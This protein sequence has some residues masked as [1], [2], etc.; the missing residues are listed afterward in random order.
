MLFWIL[1]ALLTLGAC[2]AVLL[3]AMRGGGRTTADTDFDLTV[4]Q[5]QLAELERDMARGVI[6][7]TEAQQARAEIGRRILKLAGDKQAAG[8]V[9][10]GRAGRVLATLAI[11]ALPVTSWGIYTTTGS[12]HL[13][14]QPLQ[15][16]LDAN[17][18]Q[19]PIGML[20]ARA[21]SHLTANPEDGRGWDVLAPIYYRMGRYADASVAYRNAIRLLGASDVR[22]AGLGEALAA[23]AG[24]MITDEAQAALER[25]IAIEPSNPKARF[26]LVTAMAQEGRDDDARSAWLSMRDDLPEDSPWRGAV[27]QALAE[28]DRQAAGAGPSS[29]EIEAAG[30]M[31]D[32]DRTQMI[33]DMVAGLDQRLRTNPQDA[34][35]W[36]R[37]VHSYAVMGRDDAAGDALSR[38]LEALGQD[39]EAGRALVAFAAERGV[40]A[41]N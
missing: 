31:S 19:D 36:Q 12:P 27:A 28:L 11:L 1:A 7:S 40:R 32:N 39:S 34:E 38:G 16:R 21:E 24:G 13:H 23:A 4:Y 22:E 18:E 25:A 29:E 8:G 17:Q 14:D 20:V 37:L 26:L 41:D 33:E 35:G 6:E 5:D 2:L 3:P 10:A 15:A 9:T 30:L